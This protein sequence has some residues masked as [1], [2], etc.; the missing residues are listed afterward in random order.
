M[1]QLTAPDEPAPEPAPE[2]P[3][4]K[5]IEQIEQPVQQPAAPVEHQPAAAPPPMK[6]RE[7][8]IR[9]F[10]NVGA[11]GLSVW[12]QEHMRIGAAVIEALITEGLLAEHDGRVRIK[13]QLKSAA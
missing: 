8:T 13:P 3:P 12:Q 4:A 9:A 6:S 10:E 5:Q 7:E 1:E 2:Q 11:D